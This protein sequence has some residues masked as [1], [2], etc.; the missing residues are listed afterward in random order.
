MDRHRVARVLISR[1]E[2]AADGG[3]AVV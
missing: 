3:Q 2:P 1:L